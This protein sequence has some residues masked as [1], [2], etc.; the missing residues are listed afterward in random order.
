MG[1]HAGSGFYYNTNWKAGINK[2]QAEAE[3]YYGSQDGYSGGANSCSFVYMGEYPNF[4]EKD[5][6]NFIKKQLDLLSNGEGGVIQV[7]IHSY[8]VF[9]T[10]VTEVEYLPFDSK[11]ILKRMTKGPAALV[12]CDK[13]SNKPYIVK[14]GTVVELKKKVHTFLR[15]NKY[16]N[17]FYIVGKNKSF[18]CT[19][20]YKEVKK[21]K[22]ITNDKIMVLPFYKFVYFGWYR[23]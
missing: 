16:E 22:R 23:E 13:F 1:G 12:Q 9:S 19:G 3:K 7:G 4:K 5:I 11:F 8:G 18:I 14:E 21:T 15:N 6:S 17:N 10:S 20:Q 2:L